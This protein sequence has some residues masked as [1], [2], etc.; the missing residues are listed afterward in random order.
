V[1]SCSE[2]QQRY[3]GWGRRHGSSCSEYQHLPGGAVCPAPKVWIA[4][5]KQCEKAGARL[6]TPAEVHGGAAL[7]MECQDEE[8]TV[9]TSER[10]GQGTNYLIENS[11]G[12]P[13]AR[14][15]NVSKPSAGGIANCDES[16]HPHRVVCCA[17][18]HDAKHAGA[19]KSAHG[20]KPALLPEKAGEK[21]AH[22]SAGDKLSHSS[23]P[24]LSAEKSGQKPAHASGGDKYGSKPILP[25]GKVAEK[26]THTVK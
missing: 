10:C 13:G 1:H 3:G 14:I 17:D 24:E 22:A 23:K 6:C 18:R 7:G 25:P 26:P 9:W 20:S 21:P 8:P 12:K 16:G 11:N 19:D 15:A 2:M 4:A 5:R